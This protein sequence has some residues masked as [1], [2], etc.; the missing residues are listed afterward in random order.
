MDF[1][2]LETFISVAK[3]GSFTKTAEKLFLSQP[4]VSG[5]IG[6]LEQELGVVLF[7][8]SNRK[9]ELTPA[10]RIFFSSVTEILNQKEKT[11]LELHEHNAKI[12]GILEIGASNT[13]AQY[14]LPRFLAAFHTQYPNVIFDVLQMNSQQVETGLVNG[15]LD[16]GLVGSPADNKN[17][18]YEKISQDDL[19]AI[20]PAKP[21]F[22]SMEDISLAE[23]LS[24]P[25]IVRRE[26]SATRQFF[27]NA[28][29]KSG[30]TAAMKIAA[31][32]DS[33]EMIALSVQHGLGLAVVSILSVK[34][35][36]DSGLLRL[37]PIR[38]LPLQRS[39]Y[40]AYHKSRTL[41]PLGLR[42]KEF[43]LEN[44]IAPPH[45]PV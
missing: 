39:F 34:E 19:I 33:T 13:T 16:F 9:I 24:Y 30:R 6:K 15:E 35:K 3:T 12:E 21:P 22:T 20:A 14:V 23:L 26:G 11:L 25:I 29:E 42:F 10:G 45:T 4:S 37:L 7:R 27:E 2:Q 17:L 41:S 1:K 43:I 5:H 44:N 18:L 38:D 8:R 32:F 40:F 36:A 31:Y 28:L